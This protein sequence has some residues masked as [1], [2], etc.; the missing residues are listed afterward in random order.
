MEWLLPVSLRILC[1][2]VIYPLLLKGRI[3]Q[4]NLSKRFFLQYFICA[5]LAG[6][7]ALSTGQFVLSG[8]FWTM[9]SVGIFIGVGTYLNWLTTKMN[10]SATSLFLFFDDLL[11]ITLGFIFLGE[12]G[13]LSP[14]LSVGLLI[15]LTGIV[16]FSYSNYR[17]KKV[18]TGVQHLPIRFFVYVA[19]FSTAWGIA[20]FSKRYYALEGLEIG[21]Y[22]LGWYLGTFTA[23]MIVCLKNLGIRRMALELR[24]TTQKRE[25]GLMS[26]SSVLIMLNIVL[27]FWALKLAPPDSGSAD[28]LHLGA[29]LP[30]AH[31]TINLQGEEEPDSARH[32]K[33]QLGG[34]WHYHHR[35]CFLPELNKPQTAPTHQSAAVFSLKIR[36]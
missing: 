3:V 6:I 5:V 36:S 15:C 11:A 22:L 23:A 1:I 26:V 7:F 35:H 29:C 18:Q 25:V 8:A 14:A 21:T 9:Y 24:T 2:S 12:I 34:P 32:P 30:S 4:E 17:K 31:Q 16:V 28:F 33:L 27:S 19:I 13:F 10:L 20:S